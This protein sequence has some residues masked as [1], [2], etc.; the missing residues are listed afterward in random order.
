MD[1]DFIQGVTVAIEPTSPSPCEVVRQSSASFYSRCIIIAP[2]AYLNM[3][4]KENCFLNGIKFKEKTIILVI[5][6]FIRFRIEMF[7]VS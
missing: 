5:E 4:F 2:A 1:C 6:T 7:K 3:L